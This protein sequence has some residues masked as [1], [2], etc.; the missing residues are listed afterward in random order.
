MWLRL[1]SSLGLLVKNEKPLKNL[2]GARG[3][4]YE[5]SYDNML[6]TQLGVLVILMFF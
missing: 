6:P 1:R 3:A 5:C 2:G 4:N